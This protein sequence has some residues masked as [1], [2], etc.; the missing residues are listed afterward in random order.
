[1][2]WLEIYC[3]WPKP[4]RFW[5][6]MWAV[7]RAGNVV[8]RKNNGFSRPWLPH[9]DTSKS[10]PPSETCS[11]RPAC[12]G[13]CS[14]RRNLSRVC[15][16]SRCWSWRTRSWMKSL[17]I[18]RQPTPKILSLN[19]RNPESWSGYLYLFS[20]LNL[21]VIRFPIWHVW[22]IWMSGVSGLGNQTIEKK[23]QRNLRK[24]KRE[25]TGSFY[26]SRYLQSSW[27]LNW[28]EKIL[29]E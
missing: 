13:Q 15:I 4:P 12:C 6:M 8:K 24:I 2:K 29:P 18:P 1:M 3:L 21:K 17:W 14:K 19:Q 9:F 16:S 5:H 28:I 20:H 22:C 25:G 23:L 27:T 10:S 11:N 26:L 7:R